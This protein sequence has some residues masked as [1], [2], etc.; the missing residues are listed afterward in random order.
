M[1]DTV[2]RETN[3]GVLTLTLNRP[4]AL[5]SFNIEM[6]ESLL[7]G[8]KDAARDTNVRVVV[9]T[10]AGRAFSAGQDLK[11]RTAPGVADLG[12]E[13][14]LRYNPIVLAMRKLE[15]PVIGAIN[16][17]A[18]GAGI[19]VALACDLRVAADNASFIEV[20]ARVGL[21][22]D[23][24]SSWF[25]PR[26][27]GYA[28]AAEL[29]FT[30]DPVDAQTAE[31]IGLVNRVVP[32]DQLMNETNVL[33]TRLARS[34]PIALGLAKRALNRALESGLEEQLEYE[35]QLQSIAGRSKD[36]Q[37]GV[38]AFV[39]KRPANFTGE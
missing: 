15:K 12:T 19:S 21:V 31:R 16:G 5:N 26:L 10:G 11:E 20:F 9:L 39:E 30:T 24:G 34:A 32:A 22:P 4:E 14:R 35:A 33:A 6:K 8:L 27:V 23:T 2:L 37:E 29:S 7:T 25:L 1:S 28:K 36:H 13:L 18:A 17:V 38:A 3:G